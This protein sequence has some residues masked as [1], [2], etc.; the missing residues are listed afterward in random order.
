MIVLTTKVVKTSFSRI[1]EVDGVPQNCEVAASG[2]RTW[3]YR[4]V[5]NRVLDMGQRATD[6]FIEVRKRPVLEP[7]RR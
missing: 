2:F 4:I 6:S 1:C 5:V 3:L 7:C